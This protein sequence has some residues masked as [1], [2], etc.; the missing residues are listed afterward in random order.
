MTKL[1]LC[2]L[3][4][5]ISSSAFSQKVYF[6]YLQTEN[7]QPF[8]VRMD[9]KVYSS[10]ASGYLILSKLKD[11]TYGLTVGFPQNKWPEQKFSVAMSRK[12]HGY[13]V[14]NFGEKGWG[15]F[16]LQTLAVQMASGASAQIEI[17][18]GQAD[19]EV[20]PF[21]DI[22]AKA[23]DDPSLREVRPYSADDEKS[24]GTSVKEKENK[25]SVIEIKNVVTESPVK[26]EPLMV[27][28]EEPKVENK[29]QPVTNS[30]EKTKQGITKKE[31]PKVEN[32]DQSAVNSVEKTEQVVAKKE[33]LKIEAKVAPVKE[34]VETKPL[35][36]NDYKPSIVIKKSESSSA[37][38]LGIVF[39]DQDSKGTSDTISLV[40]PDPQPIVMPKE[41]VNKVEQ[42][43]IEILPEA[44]TVKEEKPDVK[45]EPKKLYH[46]MNYCPSLAGDNDFFKL[47]KLMAAAEGDD[48]MIEEAIKYFK[49]KCFSTQQIKNLGSLFLTDN[50]KYKF[51]EVAYSY[52]SDKNKFHSL[53]AELKEDEYLSLFKSTFRN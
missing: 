28:K 45:T 26:T 34:P 23:A 51:F 13:L 21:T 40:I 20:S 17:K 27:R 18:S 39:I 36:V 31:E 25:E 46:E 33:E 44:S 41:T 8:Y 38:G 7:E 53:Q 16:D 9:K 52:V 30:I 32:K 11:S 37:E 5:I 19:K 14:K 6:I 49:T 12:D 47:R 42:K 48:N 4:S 24:A 29:E 35:A 3:F 1:L 50:G 15:L 43:F 10:S 22:L 2:F